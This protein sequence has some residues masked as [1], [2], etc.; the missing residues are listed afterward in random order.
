MT[1]ITVNK[2]AE[3][4][5]GRL[6]YALNHIGSDAGRASL[7]KACAD[8]ILGLIKQE[9]MLKR[10]PDFRKWKPLASRKRDILVK[11]GTLRDS[12]RAIVT[13]NGFT[14]VSPVPYGVF[15][16]QGTRT[17]P[18]RRM[19]PL[20]GQLSTYWGKVLNDVIIV[21]GEQVFSKAA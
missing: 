10:D 8:G 11:T 1:A 18:I 19:V 6:I 17:I 20:P 3:K 16:Q 9:F 21:W 7:V 12:F 5:M 15:H 4:R 2:A 14:I 13:P